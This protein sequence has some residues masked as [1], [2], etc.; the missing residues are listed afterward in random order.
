MQI[1]D[2]GGSTSFF[3][4]KDFQNATHCF[5]T[6][7]DYVSIGSKSFEREV[8]TDSPVQNSFAETVHLQGGGGMH[9]LLLYSRICKLYH[10]FRYNS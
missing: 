3:R 10:I 6:D 4:P 9:I 5:G 2:E 7:F 1:R 8:K